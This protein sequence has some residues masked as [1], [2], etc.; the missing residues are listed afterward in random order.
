M[1]KFIKLS[2]FLKYFLIVILS[3]SLIVEFICYFFLIFFRQIQQILDDDSTPSI[4]EEKLAALTAGERTTWARARAEHFSKGVNKTS[5]DII[6]KSAFV[7]ALDDI[8]YEFDPVINFH[9]CLNIN[10]FNNSYSFSFS[11]SFLF[12]ERKEENGF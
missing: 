5:L 6:E 8:P 7:V 2:F 4:G 1:I 10:L 3:V 11:F 12:D 9:N